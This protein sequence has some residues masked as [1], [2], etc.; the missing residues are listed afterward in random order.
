ML[1][2][3]TMEK[4]KMVQNQYLNATTSVSINSICLFV[5][6]FL[7]YVHICQTSKYEATSNS[8]IFI[9]KMEVSEL[10]LFFRNVEPAF[11]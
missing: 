4:Q 11:F 8:V 10:G 5:C 1:L 6:L 9:K 3:S 2:F 7:R